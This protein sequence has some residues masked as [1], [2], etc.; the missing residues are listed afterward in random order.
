M[1]ELVAANAAANGGYLVDDA[2][3][4]YELQAAV[5]TKEAQA[6]MRQGASASIA[7]RTRR[8][9]GGRTFLQLH[10]ALSSTPHTQPQSLLYPALISPPAHYSYPVDA[11]VLESSIRSQRWRQ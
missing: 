3:E 1:G 7:T 2:E 6:T 11:R 5:G 10:G 4:Y 9:A 8:K